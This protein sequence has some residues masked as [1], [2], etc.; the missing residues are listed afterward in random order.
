MQTEAGEAAG[1]GSGEIVQPS[2][3][4]SEAFMQ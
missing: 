1:S 2:L 3:P 4:G